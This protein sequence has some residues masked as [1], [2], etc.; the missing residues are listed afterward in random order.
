[1]QRPRAF[2]VGR[3]RQILSVVAQRGAVTFERSLRSDDGAPRRLGMRCA[4][5]VFACAD[6]HGCAL[7]ASHCPGGEI[8]RHVH[9]FGLADPTGSQ[10][11][12]HEGPGHAKECGGGDERDVVARY[13]G[14]ESGARSQRPV[15]EA[16]SATRGEGRE[17]RQPY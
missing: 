5:L 1:M 9:T 15:Q 17:D 7:G 4:G 10:L 16:R 3:T 11:Q 6:R 13:S 12:C 8:P 14:C 2:D